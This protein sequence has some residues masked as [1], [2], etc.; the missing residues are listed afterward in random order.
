[1]P[2]RARHRDTQHPIR[3]GL[4]IGAGH[5][6]SGTR[7]LDVMLLTEKKIQTEAYS[8]NQLGYNVTC[9]S[10]RPSSSGGGSRWNRSGYEVTARQ[11]GYRIPALPR[12][13]HT[14]LLPTDP[15]WCQ[16]PTHSAATAASLAPM[17]ARARH[18]DTQHPI[19][20]G[21]WIGA[22]HLGSGTRGLDV[23]LLTEKKIQ[24]EAYSHNQL[25]YNVTC[26][27]ARPS[28]SGGGSRWNRSGYEVTARQVGYRIPA[29][30]R[31]EHSEL[32]DIHR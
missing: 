1:M 30:P 6:G 8:H 16:P 7:G 27:S 2:A 14:H 23:M 18:R 9:L 15:P 20:K 19:R 29:L 4:W 24:T 12:A 5:L 3:K 26:L 10:A 13:E 28:S 11:V 21:L 22:G 25:G 32:R 17:P 31:A